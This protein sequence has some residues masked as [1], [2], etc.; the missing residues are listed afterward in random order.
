[1]EQG[2]GGEE[3]R[4]G[5]GKERDRG[6]AI[7]TVQSLACHIL[8][9]TRG[10]RPRKGVLQQSLRALTHILQRHRP[11]TAVLPSSTSSCQWLPHAH[12]PL[13]HAHSPLPHAHSPLLHAHSP[14]LHAHSPLFH[15]LLTGCLK[16]NLLHDP[17]ILLAAWWAPHHPTFMPELKEE[18]VVASLAVPLGRGG[19]IAM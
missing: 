11:V 16:Y 19:G 17:P 14:L 4:G 13:P 9:L 5:V 10:G 7:N 6:I 15:A 3:R 12:S 1:M 2:G 8:G 18:G